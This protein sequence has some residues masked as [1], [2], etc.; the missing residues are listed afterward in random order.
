MTLPNI[1]DIAKIGITT[2][3]SYSKTNGITD[4]S[5]TINPFIQGLR[6]IVI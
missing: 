4:S 3:I 5:A 1:A 2:L 6:F